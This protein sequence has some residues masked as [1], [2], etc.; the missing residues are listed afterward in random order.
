MGSKKITHVHVYLIGFVIMVIVGVALYFLLLKPLNETNE[1]LAG[2]IATLEGTNANVDGKT[3]RYDQ[4]TAAE[5]ALAEAKSRKAGKEAQLA[6][7][8][9]RKQL[10]ASQ[11]LKIETTQPALLST[12]MPRWLMLPQRVVTSMENWA[13]SRGKKLGLDK[14]ETTFA[15][16]APSTDPAAIPKAIVA[17]NL[18]QMSVTGD[19]NRVMRWVKDWNNAPLLVAVNDLKCSVADRDGKVTATASL[20]V[21]IFP[22]GPGAGAGA[23][24]AVNVAGQGGGLPA[25]GG[26]PGVGG[27]AGIGNGP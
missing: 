5:A 9:R 21:Y 16:N 10:P 17:W 8:E 13:T 12:T 23:A 26:Y 22:T 25:T 14:V 11:T 18:G 4:K 19:F 24:G 20:N 15:A 1:Q 2:A 3:F 6:S 27:T 7:L